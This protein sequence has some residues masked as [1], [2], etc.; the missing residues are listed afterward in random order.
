MAH[1][2]LFLHLSVGNISHIDR[3]TVKVFCDFLHRSVPS[4]HNEKVDDD[5][6]ED[7]EYTI[8]KV[9][10]PVEGVQGNGVD[11]LVEE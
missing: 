5:N 1:D 7:E 4:L 3:I 10:L 6:F 8:A 9:I 11:V 2:T